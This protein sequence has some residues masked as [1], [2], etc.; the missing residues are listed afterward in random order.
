M[1]VVAQEIRDSDEPEIVVELRTIEKLI[2][3]RTPPVSSFPSKSMY[4]DRRL[5]LLAD[6]SFVLVLVG[7]KLDFQAE[8]TIRR[9]NQVA[10]ACFFRGARRHGE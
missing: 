1:G 9:D 8:H 6:N 3:N 4:S 2:Y 10:E 7:F 5:Y